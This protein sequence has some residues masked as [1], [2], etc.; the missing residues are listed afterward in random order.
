MI[1]YDLETPALLLDLDAMERNQT[2][3]M[4]FFKTA[5][6]HLRPHTKTH[7]T[8][9]LA[10][11]QLQAGAQGI[12][13]GNLGEAEVMIA[14]GIR[15]VLVTKEIVQPQ[16]IA[17]V[18]ELARESEIIVVADDEKVVEQ[19]VDVAQNAGVEIRML[20][21]VDVR[22]ERAGVAPMEPARKLAQRIASERGLRFMGLMGY[23]GSMHNLDAAERARKCHDSLAALVETR[24]LVDRSGIAVDIVSV[25]ASSTYKTAAHVAG[26]TEVQAGSY[27][28][29]DARYLAPWSDF[30]CALSVLTTVI[31]R[32][33][34]T[35]VTIDAGQKKLSSDAGLPRVKN[36]DGVRLVALNEEHGILEAVDSASSL[37]VG[38]PLEIIPSHGGTTINL[39]E[40]MYGVRGEK[41]E[42]VFEIL[43]RGK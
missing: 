14:A 7:R 32:P 37:H 38:D 41:V 2:R 28:T 12:C 35:R 29:G 4:E 5:P 9:A 19:F 13:C 24:D 8:P 10:K 16:Q 30:E 17:R 33:K 11:L 1:K 20:V 6:A 42:T 27:L 25:G 3:M 34:Q 22:L 15:D 40:K 23:E 21:E 36:C 43:G 18:A 39:Y 26:V 31:S